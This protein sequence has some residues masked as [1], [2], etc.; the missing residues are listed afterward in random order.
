MLLLLPVL[1]SMASAAPL[2]SVGSRWSRVGPAAS[3]TAV[4]LHPQRARLQAAGSETGEV[5][6]SSDGGAS[7]RRALTGSLEGNRRSAGPDVEGAIEQV[8][9]DVD[10]ETLGDV[11][12]LE[13]GNEAL[14]DAAAQLAEVIDDAVESSSRRSSSVPSVHRVVFLGDRLF[15]AREDGLWSGSMEGTAW[16]RVVEGPVHD[17]VS[18]NLGYVAATDDGV[19]VSGDGA[20]WFDPI[21]GSEGLTVTQ[22]YGFP[23]GTLFGATSSG[24][25]RSDGF[26]WWQ[27]NTVVSEGMIAHGGPFGDQSLLVTGTAERL[28][29]SSDA[30]ASSVPMNGPRVPG[31]SR[32]VRQSAGHWWMAS[33]DGVWQTVDWGSTVEPMSRGLPGPAVA[34]LTVGVG[35]ALV[36]TPSGLFELR[37]PSTVVVGESSP[38]VPMPAPAALIGS[39]LG[40]AGVQLPRRTAALARWLP[41]VNVNGRTTSA[42]GLRYDSGLDLDDP[43]LDASAATIRPFRRDWRVGVELRWSPSGRQSAAFGSAAGDIA[44]AELGVDLSGSLQ[45]GSTRG[46]YERELAARIVRLVGEHDLAVHRRQE[47]RRAPLIEQVLVELRVREIEGELDALTDGGV[48]EWRIA[49]DDPEEAG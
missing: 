20:T 49:S 14:E 26:D 38:G 35:R 13:S 40:R 29:V 37:E 19:R 22:L 46:S 18:T 15:A 10:L 48:S 27:V 36:A 43:V 2:G 44:G 24:L 6:V 8:L 39:S 1:S 17:V 33:A 47:I 21:D 34:D 3:M 23:D 28:W 16:S 5:W 7:W 45:E 4:A 31:V 42:D 41:L 12:A 9:A 11:E 30:G 32:I 25:W